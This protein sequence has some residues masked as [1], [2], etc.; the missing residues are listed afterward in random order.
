MFVS[1]SFVSQV[2]WG[3]HRLAKWMLH[4]QR[5]CV[6]PRN[7][8]LFIASEGLLFSWRETLS[9]PIYLIQERP[10][11]CTLRTASKNAQ[12]ARLRQV[13]PPNRAA[14]RAERQT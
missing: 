8:S 12:D 5:V 1:V 4:T 9:H 14:E 3:Q 13:A 7:T 2:L 11:P 10:G 6:Q